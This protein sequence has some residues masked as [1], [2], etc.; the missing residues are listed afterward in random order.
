MTLS[1]DDVSPIWPIA[2][3]VTRRGTRRTNPGLFG[4]GNLVERGD[5]KAYGAN[6]TSDDSGIAHYDAAFFREV[7]RTGRAQGPRAQSDHAV[8]RVPESER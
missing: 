7:M 3:D 8:D 2:A 6:I 5:V 4:G 1:A